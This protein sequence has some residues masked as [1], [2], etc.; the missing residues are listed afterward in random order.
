MNINGS[1]AKQNI[2]KKIKTGLLS[3]QNES[4]KHKRINYEKIWHPLKEELAVKF[5]KEFNILGGKFMYCENEEEALR[6]IKS[7]TDYFNWTSIFC[8]HPKT[9]HNLNIC[10]DTLPLTE[11]IVDA[12]VII[13]DCDYLISRTGSI[14][15]SAKNQ[16]RKNTVF[17]PIHMVI[18][19]ASQLKNSL[20]EVINLQ[21]IQ[22]MD[23]SM[24]SIITGHSRTADI[25]KTLVIGVH[26]PK[27]LYV[28]FIDSP[29]C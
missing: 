21:T 13:T 7:L 25:E 17:A 8:N 2:I 29:T 11:N 5:A 12:Q 15:V 9:I 6:N 22:A 24:V 19:Y 3:S 4:I 23:T 26:G 27:E 1:D 28:L 20:E 18:A 14:V 16:N 10:S